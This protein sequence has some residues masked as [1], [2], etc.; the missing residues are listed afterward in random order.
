ERG[1][2]EGGVGGA[3]LE[4][5]AEERVEALVAD[6]LGGAGR[7]AAIARPREDEADGAG[8]EDHDGEREGEPGTAARGRGGVRALAR[9]EA[10]E[11]GAELFRRLV[12]GVGSL[13][14]RL[15]RDRL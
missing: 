15:P 11:V 13:G 6:E 1:L 8:A 10:V 4:L 2:E 7:L 12:A 3:G 14:H 5:P 9:E